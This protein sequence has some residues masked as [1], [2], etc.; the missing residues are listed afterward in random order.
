MRS[1]KQIKVEIDEHDPTVI[2]VDG[3]KFRP[4][5]ETS[6]KIGIPFY[7]L[8]EIGIPKTKS[9]YSIVYL[10]YLWHQH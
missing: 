3:E 5:K 6:K 7:T 4:V 9:I 2:I 8:V 1:Q 10:V